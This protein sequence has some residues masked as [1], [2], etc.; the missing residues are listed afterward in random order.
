M[1]CCTGITE[2]L[3]AKFDYITIDI[4]LNEKKQRTANIIDIGIP[5]T[6][7]QEDRKRKN[8]EDRIRKNK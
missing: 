5:L 2:I 4:L 8:Q 1:S 6:K 3:Q 7:N